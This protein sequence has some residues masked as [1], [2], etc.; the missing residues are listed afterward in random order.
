MSTEYNESYWD[1]FD[2]VSINVVKFQI[3]CKNFKQKHN[4]IFNN[5][6]VIIELTFYFTI[7]LHLLDYFR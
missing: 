6:S 2:L 3:N 1:E 7:F 5:V 4:F